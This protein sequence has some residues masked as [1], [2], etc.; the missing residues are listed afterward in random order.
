MI[1]YMNTGE[2]PYNLQPG[3]SKGFIQN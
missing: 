3:I 1:D 2:R